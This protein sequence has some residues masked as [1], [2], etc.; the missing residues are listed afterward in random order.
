MQDKNNKKGW[1]KTKNIRW[2]QLKEVTGQIWYNK[3]EMTHNTWGEITSKPKNENSLNISQNT[4]GVSV[5]NSVAT[6]SST[7]EVNQDQF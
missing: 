3:V 7:T 5:E 6:K 2:K 4:P 1:N